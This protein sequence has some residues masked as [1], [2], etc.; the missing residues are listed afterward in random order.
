M[1]RLT[2][3]LVLMLHGLRAMLLQLLFVVS[4]TEATLLIL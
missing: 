1:L 2:L 4:A 3:M